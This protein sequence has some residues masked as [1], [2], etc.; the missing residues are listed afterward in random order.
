MRVVAHPLAESHDLQ[1]YTWLLYQAVRAEGVEVGGLRLFELVRHPPAIV[2]LHWPEH[3]LHRGPLMRHLR[4]VLL[5]GALSI[6]RRRGT[7]LVW[8]AHNARPHDTPADGFGDRFLRA[9]DRRV[10]GVLLLSDAGVAEVMAE[11]PGLRSAERFHTRHGHFRDAYRDAPARSAARAGLGLPADRPVVA[12]CGQVRPYKGVEDLVDAAAPLDVELLVAG[13][14]PDQ[15]LRDVL[16]AA[17]AA[18]PRLHLRLGRLPASTMATAVR[19]ADLVVLPYRSVLNSGSVLLALSLDRPVLVPDTPT[20]G[21]LAQE[22]GRAWVQRYSG[23]RLG[24]E[25]LAVALDRRP[26]GTPDLRLYEW[27]LVAKATVEAYR[28]LGRRPAEEVATC[29]SSS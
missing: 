26:R 3:V 18:S 15:G 1:P 7:R 9:F 16:E 13:P 4:G 12:F 10:D 24:S 8:T 17:A 6:A 22:V 11:R 29:A 19:A 21:E 5:L 14:C 2:H 27:D 25:D 28:S 20:F 23:R